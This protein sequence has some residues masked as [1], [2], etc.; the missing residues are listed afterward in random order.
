MTVREIAIPGIVVMNLIPHMRFIDTIHEVAIS[1]ITMISIHAAFVLG[2][3]I[4]LQ[5]DTT[6]TFTEITGAVALLNGAF[7]I[8]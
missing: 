5:K 2:M 6:K 1:D 8:L 3:Y 7:H 4:H